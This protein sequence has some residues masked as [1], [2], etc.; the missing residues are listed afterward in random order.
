[1]LL[2]QRHLWHCALSLSQTC[3]FLIHTLLLEGGFGCRLFISPRSDAPEVTA[4]TSPFPSQDTLPA[5]A[6]QAL[7]WYVCQSVISTWPCLSD[8][9]TSGNGAQEWGDCLHHD[10]LVLAVEGGEHTGP[11][12]LC[13]QKYK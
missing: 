12:H 7:G 6:I 2:W 9:L 8:H 5:G 11:G 4:T 1:M 3:S 10:K 13:L